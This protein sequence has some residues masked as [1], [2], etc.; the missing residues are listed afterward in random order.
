MPKSKDRIPEEFQSIEKIQ[1]FWDTHSTADYWDE[2]EDVEMQLSPALKSKLELKKLYSLLG[3][4]KQHIADIE[5]KAKLENM[6]SRQ[7]IS[8]WILDM[9]KTL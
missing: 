7:L 9:L 5:A 1:E 8:K 4:S 3:L 2:M 6:D